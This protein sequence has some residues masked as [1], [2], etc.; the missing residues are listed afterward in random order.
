MVVIVDGNKVS[1]LQVT[2]S[3][4]SLTG[5]TLHSTAITE[6]AV[7]VVVKE[8]V[9]RLVEDSTAVSL[10]NGQTNGVGET[11]TKG[12]S[13]HLNT[14]SVVSFGVTGGNAVNL[15]NHQLV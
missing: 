5:N 12:T 4:S 15:L 2:S 6:V 11:L 9:S 8:V 3:G 7:C 14:R 10:G 13:G 1:E